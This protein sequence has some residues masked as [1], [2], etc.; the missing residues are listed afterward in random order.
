MRKKRHNKENIFIDL[1]S[2][3]D[4]VFILLMVVMLN[5]Q[6]M[7]NQADIQRVDASRAEKE[8]LVNLKL[9]KKQMETVDELW[10]ISVD[11]SYD[12]EDVTKRQIR[13]LKMG[14]DV[15]DSIEM[16][17][18]NTKEPLDKLKA[19]L[20][21]YI[22]SWI[23]SNQYTENPKPIILSINENDDHILYRDEK[24]IQE[25]FYELKDKY[26]DVYLR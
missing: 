6:E 11:A 4:V 3:L 2:L 13:I 15:E 24:A 9:Y 20:D 5:G 18:T 21:S 17:G 1:T 8:A 7:S 26:K 12:S 25:I 19:S 10:M 16:D 14:E 22:V 23:T